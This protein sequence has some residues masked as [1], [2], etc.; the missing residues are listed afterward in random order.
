M[1]ATVGASDMALIREIRN[2]LES[3]FV[4]G[5]RYAIRDRLCRLRWG[6]AGGPVV[7]STDVELVKRLLDPVF[8]E[9]RKNFPIER[10]L[11]VELT[12]FRIA[13]PDD[14]GKDREPH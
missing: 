8:R 2:P 14:P 10:A 5:V 1:Y 4:L 12:F 9:R 11:E 13:D 6:A 7:D 3:V